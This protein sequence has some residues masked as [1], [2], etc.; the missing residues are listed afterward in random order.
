MM[1]NVVAQLSSSSLP[2]KAICCFKS[3]ISNSICFLKSFAISLNDLKS[4]HGPISCQLSNYY[5][6]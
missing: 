3:G 5:F 1:K 2:I 6:Y 4:I